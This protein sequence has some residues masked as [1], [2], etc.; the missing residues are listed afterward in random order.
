MTVCGCMNC[1]FFVF[2]FMVGIMDDG[3]IGG[4]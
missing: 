1:E 2:H 3:L 4:F